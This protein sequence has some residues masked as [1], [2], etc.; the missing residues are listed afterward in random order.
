[1]N[2]TRADNQI[3][4][5]VLHRDLTADAQRRTER[6][7]D[8]LLAHFPW[9]H[10]HTATCG[11]STLIVWGHNEIAQRVRTTADG[12]L[13]AVVGSPHGPFGWDSVADTLPADLR[14]PWE[15][16]CVL[17]QADS[18]SQR[19]DAWSDWTGSIPIWHARGG[20][21]L[22]ASSVEPL[23]VAA[24]DAGPAD[25]LPRGLYALLALG[26]CVGND[27]IF[28]Q[29]SVAP[30][31]SHTWWTDR[32]SDPSR[33]REEAVCAPDHGTRRLNTVPATDARWTQGLNELRDE[34]YEL[35]RRTCQA[36]LASSPA[37]VLPLSGGLDSRLIAGL[38]VD[39]G[40]RFT[41][42]TY[43]DFWNEAT[44]AQQ[45]AA[46]LNI[47]WQHVDMGRAYHADFAPLWADWFGSSSFFHGMYQMPFLSRLPDPGRTLWLASGFFGDPLAGNHTDALVRGYAEG[48][49][50]GALRVFAPFWP[51][52][53]LAS[54]VTF[55]THAVH[56]EL[57]EL[58]Q[59]DINSYPGADFQRMLYFD[60]WH[61]QRRLIFY[62]PM[63]YNYYACLAA[64]FVD[65]TYAA[66]WLSVPRAVLTRRLLQKEMLRSHLPKLAAIGGS[67]HKRPLQMSLRYHLLD[68]VANL[69]PRAWRVGPL[70][71]WNPRDNTSN[72]ECFHTHPERSL[73]PIREVRDALDELFNGQVLDRTIRRA[74]AFDRQAC[75]Q[76]AAVQPIALRCRRET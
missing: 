41:A 1:M 51:Q 40:V 45:V 23:V 12:R 18:R 43:G 76:I 17:L 44:W 14:L 28:R 63:M 34:L 73:W 19:W 60:L 36:A 67:F 32:T 27:T 16:R 58:L 50:E 57:A 24:T 3:V 29:I 13:Q 20:P 53:E 4:G 9:L 38:G 71:E 74:Q 55:D 39:L 65:R 6:A 33:D 25:F 46:T 70:R 21:G 61:R 11:R 2:A 68:L 5:F 75:L 62:Q 52:D 7:L 22:I 47:P 26:H 31:D 66:F 42:Y 15:G 56:S 69:L 49:A 59:A 10:R 48:G 72:E 35:S 8:Q 30:P 37:W 64:P 54:L